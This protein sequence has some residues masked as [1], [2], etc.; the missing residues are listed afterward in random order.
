MLLKRIVCHALLKYHFL[1]SLIYSWCCRFLGRLHCL[2]LTKCT[3]CSFHWNLLMFKNI[4]GIAAWNLCS[5]SDLCS[6]NS[7]GNLGFPLTTSQRSR[8]NF[9][10]SG[11]VYAVP[12]LSLGVSLSV[13]LPLKVKWGVTY[14]T[15]QYWL[16]SERIFSQSICSLF[17]FVLDGTPVDGCLL[18]FFR[19]R[20]KVMS[21]S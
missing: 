15:D 5:L 21:E 11:F 18:F 16:N 20:S 14:Y 10:M 9:G 6:T 13:V 4:S 2:M 7:F 17:L 1:S 8:Q 19:L 12:A 3:V